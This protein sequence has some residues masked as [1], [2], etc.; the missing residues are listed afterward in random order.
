MKID[1]T[2]E[3]DRKEIWRPN[4]AVEVYKKYSMRDRDQP[5]SQMRRMQH[6]QI[7]LGHDMTPFDVNSKIVASRQSRPSET[8][9][10]D[11]YKKLQA[12]V[13]TAQPRFSNSYYAN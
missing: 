1:Q 9:Y 4:S 3:R 5:E 10:E 13:K 7:D 12:K 2:E 11:P 8:L 6:S